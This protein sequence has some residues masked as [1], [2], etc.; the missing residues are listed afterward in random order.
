ML[1]LFVVCFFVL[2]F[3]AILLACGGSQARGPIGTIATGLRHSHTTQ[4][5]HLR[6]APQLV[7]T[8]DP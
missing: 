6:P 2:L 4:D 8:L 7:A 3:G 5:L 1:I